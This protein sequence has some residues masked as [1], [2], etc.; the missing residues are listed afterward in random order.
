MP[1]L[2]LKNIFSNAK[3]VITFL[4]L[5]GGLATIL[6]Q[7]TER[8]AAFLSAS[9]K[10]I[11]MGVGT[12]TWQ[13]PQQPQILGVT[14]NCDLVTSEESVTLSWQQPESDTAG[15]E[16]Y[17]IGTADNPYF[18]ELNGAVFTTQLSLAEGSSEFQV[19]A[20]DDRG[21][22]SQ[23][24]T[25]CTVVKDSINPSIELV[26]PSTNLISDSVAITADVEDSNLEEVKIVV[27][28][29]QNQVVSQSTG[30]ELNWDVSSLE[31]GEYLISVAA[32]D[33]AGHVASLEKS[34]TLDLDKPVANIAMNVPQLEDTLITNGGFE[35]G[36]ENWT[37][38]GSFEISGLNSVAAQP[39][40]G[41][42][43][44]VLGSENQVNQVSLLSTDLNTATF[45]TTENAAA[46]NNAAQPIETI[47]FWYY[48]DP[49]QAV[50][51]TEGMMVFVGD[52]LV[53][54][55]WL[56]QDQ[57]VWKYVQA[58]VSDIADKSITVA[59]YHD[60]D[61]TT[62][63]QLYLDGF[64]ANQTFALEDI[65]FDV[66]VSDNRKQATAFVSYTVDGQEVVISTQSQTSFTLSQA[67]DNAVLTYW[68]EDEAGNVAD[69]RQLF[70]PIISQA[71]FETEQTDDLLQ[72]QATDGEESSTGL[73]AE[74][75]DT[76]DYSFELVIT[77]LD[78]PSQGEYT[79]VY[80][81]GDDAQAG[82]IQEAIQGE[83]QT[84]EAEI[85]ASTV[86]VSDLY[87][88]TCSS[89]GEQCS[90]H[91]NVRDIMVVVRVIDQAGQ[92]TEYQF[93]YAGNWVT[94][95]S[96]P[97]NVDADGDEA[98][99]ADAAI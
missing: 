99:S 82:S 52:E 97:T 79:I 43:A 42:L 5:L 41:V 29:D 47:S 84:G 7:D 86:T 10:D 20:V 80:S 61:Q 54:E 40:Q 24:S 67:P 12:D 92:T 69:Q 88:G 9:L 60:E 64:V 18:I 90:P 13:P 28:N 50:A 8:T 96:N 17:F 78:H 30:T 31:S 66:S 34:I 32:T 65:G 19:R 14:T 53:F 44:A 72:A 58:D 25:V 22:E 76:G 2:Q 3:L 56:T 16:K 26:S 21:K 36:V 74:L 59:Y 95:I 1:K 55:D 91:Q 46:V 38:Q 48:L 35:D 6:L 68:A 45:N 27:S 98:E 89:A 73:A 81:H 4:V 85:T 83:F 49:T 37:M 94:A 70:V 87:F 15:I 75:L 63:G 23:P 71:A 62:G 11:G 33:K 77:N 93:E 51:E 39:N 57:P